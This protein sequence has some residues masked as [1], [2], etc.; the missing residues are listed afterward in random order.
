[1]RLLFPAGTPRRMP[2]EEI[3]TTAYL[4]FCFRP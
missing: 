3:A 2:I 1:M 4:T